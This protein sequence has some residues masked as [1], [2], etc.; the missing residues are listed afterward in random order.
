M[1]NLIAF[2][3]ALLS[4]PR[5]FSNGKH[6]YYGSHLLLAI[7]LFP[8]SVENSPGFDCVYVF[9]T[10]TESQLQ[11]HIGTSAQKPEGVARLNQSLFF[12]YLP[13]L[14]GL[15]SKCPALKAFHKRQYGRHG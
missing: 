6:S 9:Y 7:R 11:I 3:R 14:L 4:P 2:K 1:D 13:E 8:I 15:Y 12:I 5:D 10:N